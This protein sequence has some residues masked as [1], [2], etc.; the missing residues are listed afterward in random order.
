M[1][2]AAAKV[3][4]A[5]RMPFAAQRKPALPLK[6]LGLCVPVR[7]SLI[8]EFVGVDGGNF[9]CGDGFE[10]FADGVGGEA[11]GEE[12]AVEA[13]DF[14]VGDFAA[15]E[16]EFAFDAMADRE[17]L[18]FVVGVGFDGRLD[19]GVGNA[20]GAEIARDAKFSLATD[21]GALARELLREARVVELAVFLHAG[22]DELG[23]KFVGRAAIEQT[24]HFFYGVWA[25]HQSA[26]SDIVEFLLGID[27][28]R[29]REHEGSME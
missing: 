13:G 16:F 18:Q 5:G 23:E 3:K 11:G 12:A 19:V 17:A 10:F 1:G 29:G 15:R 21:F 26:Q 28:F 25:A 9:F 8:D 4:N 6:T 14:F 20:A 27:F 24:L 22:H 2:E 7:R